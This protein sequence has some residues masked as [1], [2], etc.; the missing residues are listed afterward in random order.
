MDSEFS[1]IKQKLLIEHLIT[2]TTL[3]QRAGAILK[4]SYFDKEFRSSIKFILKHSDEYKAL[5]TPKQ[6][7][8]ETGVQF[9]II[10]N[11]REQDHDWVLNET[12]RFCQRAAIV[13]AIS[14]TP[15]LIESGD[16]GEVEQIVKES[17]LVGLQKDL[18]LSYFDNPRE[19][20]ERMRLKSLIP[21]G[22]NLIDRKLYGG[23]NRGE[24]TIFTA[25]SGVGKSL[26]LQNICLNWVEGATYYYGE[27]LKR[28]KPLNAMYITLELSEELT[29]KRLDSM[30]TNIDAREIFKEIEK[31]ELMVRMKGKN[32]ARLQIKYIPAGSTVNTIKALLR[33]YEI[34]EGIRIDALAV[35]YLDLLH[36][37]GKNIDVSNLFVKDKFVTEELRSLANELDIICV[38]AS[39]LNR[40][41]VDETEHSQAMIGGGISK[42]QTADNVLSIYSNASMRERGVFEVQFLKTRS[43]SGVGSKVEVGFNVTSLRIA[44]IDEYEVIAKDGKSQDL[45]DIITSPTKLRTTTK[46]IFSQ[47][48]K[49]AE[50]TIDT[51]K[52]SQDIAESPIEVVS[53]TDRLQRLQDANK[54]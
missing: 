15:D 37:I 23:L 45:R 25:G 12:E 39:Q 29:S 18:G 31:V 24:L 52:E 20:L 32:S 1:D 35:D 44:D 43:S 16:Y 41:A 47:I 3:F 36:P 13:Q 46:D 49:P 17:M 28:Y 21:T 40:S 19:R 2:N 9:E 54:I 50:N 8:A 42:I 6:I 22:W 34:Q 26:F 38:S 10:E 14:K 48:Q 30:V 7:K 51:P 4:P 5:P 27:T 11:I 53:A 33:E